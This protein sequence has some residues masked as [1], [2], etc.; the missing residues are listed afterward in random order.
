LD[1]W[2]SRRACSSSTLLDTNETCVDCEGARQ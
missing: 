1:S 2:V